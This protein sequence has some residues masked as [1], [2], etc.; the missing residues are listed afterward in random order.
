M[1]LLTAFIWG[2]AFVAQSSGADLLPAFTFNGFR[3]ALA[4]IALIPVI[5]FRRMKSRSSQ[6]SSSYPDAG[7]NEAESIFP[8]GSMK[9][10]IAGGI[11]TGAV[12]FFSSGIQQYAMAY[13]TAAK[14]GFITTLYVIIVPVLGIFFRKK[15]MPV[16]WLCA[17]VAIIGLYLLAIKPGTFTLSQGDF[18]V[19]I[20]AFGFSFHIM[21]IDYFSPKADCISLSCL[22]FAVVSVL[23]FITALLTEEIVIA[24]VTPALFPLLYTG[25]LSSAVAYTMQVAAQKYAEPAVA[26]LILSL[27]SV[28]A[29]ICGVFFL[30]EFLTLRETA[31]CILVFAAVVLAQVPPSVFTG[32]RKSEK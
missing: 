8:A 26:S 15:V 24:D 9:A 18:Y 1:L 23:S 28:F 20:C 31:G 25:V 14:A 22:Q 2:S 3:Y 5:I 30:H 19:L 17:V 21:V 4:V 13:T 27:E 7:I 12:L 29:A 10:L 11:L 32:K 16:I 6:D